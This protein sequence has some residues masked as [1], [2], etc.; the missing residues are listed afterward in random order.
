M[1]R[2]LVSGVT[3]GGGEVSGVTVSFRGEE[4]WLDYVF[5]AV[6]D[7]GADTP[8]L[9]GSLPAEATISHA[10]YYTGKAIGSGDEGALT[11]VTKL[12]TLAAF[13]DVGLYG[14]FDEEIWNIAGDAL[15]TLR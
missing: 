5:A 8:A 10:R 1:D 7:L 11:D 4:G 12:A 3:L 15:P 9:V 2:A 6:S 13:C 14:E